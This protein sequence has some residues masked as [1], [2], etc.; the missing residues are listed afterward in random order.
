MHIYTY[1]YTFVCVCCVCALTWVSIVRGGEAAML[2]FSSVEFLIPR[3]LARSLCLFL[4]TFSLS[5]PP[6]PLSPLPPPSHS[7]LSLS[8][9]VNPFRWPTYRAQC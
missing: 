4:L 5:I 8:F 2:S 9:Y 6:I 1:T 3:S 7:H